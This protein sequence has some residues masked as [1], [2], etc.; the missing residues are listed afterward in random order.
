[1]KM[2]KKLINIVAGI[3]LIVVGVILSLDIIL[4]FA[5]A[6]LGIFLIMIGMSLLARRL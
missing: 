3:V 5:I 4:K 2:R 6:A 1:M